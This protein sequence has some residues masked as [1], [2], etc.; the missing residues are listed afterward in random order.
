MA[1]S[2]KTR[3]AGAFALLLVLAPAG[4]TG[5]GVTV[6]APE[7]VAE[8]WIVATDESAVLTV[9]G[10]EWSLITDPA[11][12]SIS[13]LGDGAFHPMSVQEVEAALRDLGAAGVRAEGRIL[14]LP[15]PRRDHLKSSCENGTIFLTPG[16]REVHPAHVH[17]TVV[18]ETGHL[19]Q[20]RLLPEGSASWTEYRELRGLESDRYVETARHRDRP[21]EIFAEDFRVLRGG[22]LARGPH[23]NGDLPDP[24]GVPGLEAW[25]ER[26]LTEGDAAAPPE[27]FPNPFSTARG[28]E[29][30]IRFRRAGP[31]GPGTADVFDVAGRRVRIL[32]STVMDGDGGRTFRWNGR[33]PAGIRTASG[34][35][36]VRWREN[37]GAGIAR[38]QIL[39]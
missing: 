36:F 34:F 24:R 32:T 35:Y 29:M 7:D 39:H 11:D 16:I 33:D 37:P 22:P 17:A 14:I 19:I 23:E 26:V 30:E 20:R 27:S 28:D 10:Q 25:L 8:R 3:V 13:T 38:V 12:P 1:H 9:G 2:G 18:H 21:R 31:A 4:P 5:A 15:Y 6:H